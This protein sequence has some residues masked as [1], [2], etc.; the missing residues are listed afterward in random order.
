MGIG[1]GLAQS[2]VLRR[3][4]ERAPQYSVKHEVAEKQVGAQ[5]IVLV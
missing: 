1:T 2:R 5:N 3:F 4:C